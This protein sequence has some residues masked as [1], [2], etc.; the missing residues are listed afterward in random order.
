[1]MSMTLTAAEISQ[2][3][4]QG[5][6][7]SFML[8]KSGGWM[9]AARAR[10]TI[11]MQPAETGM[12]ELYAFNTEGGGYVIASADDRTLPVLGYSLTPP[13]LPR[14]LRPS[15]PSMRQMLMLPMPMHT[16]TTCKAG[17]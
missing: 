17:G 16:S 7:C 8:Q 10:K 9:A 2:Q 15:A 14:T 13:S 4:A 6:A 12:P 5:N 3:Q 11:N 1:M